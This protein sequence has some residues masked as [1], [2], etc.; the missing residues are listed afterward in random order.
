MKARRDHVSPLSTQAIVVLKDLQRITSGRRYLFPHLSGKGFTTPNRLTYA[1]RDM[2]LG[3][4]TT[5]HCWR[6]TFSTWAS[7]SGYRPEAIEQQLAHV[8]AGDVQQ[9]TAAGSEKDA[10]AG[11]GA[12]YLRATEDSGTV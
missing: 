2:N 10:V 12:D 6:I 7:E 11:L 4:S 1:M 5:Q 9:G 3:R 8:E